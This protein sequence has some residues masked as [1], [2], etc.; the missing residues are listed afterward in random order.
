MFLCTFSFVWVY[1]LTTKSEQPLQW[2][3]VIFHILFSG[4]QHCSYNFCLLR[5]L[6]FGGSSGNFQFFSPIIRLLFFCS[7][8]HLPGPV[9]E[10][11]KFI[12]Y[13]FIYLFI[14][15]ETTAGS[16]ARDFS[17]FFISK[18]IDFFY[19]SVF[20]AIYT[21]YLSFDIPTSLISHTCEFCQ[22]IA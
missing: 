13:L 4:V 3:S 11:R 18:L 6:T 1:K 14:V 19:I 16:V 12:I 8:R 17:S 22:A 10:A 15:A 7:I 9:F 21:I 2:S 5:Q 20:S